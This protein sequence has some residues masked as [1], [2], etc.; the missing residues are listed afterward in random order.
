MKGD[1]IGNGYHG[2]DL[3]FLPWLYVRGVCNAD[4]CQQSAADQ[5]RQ[6]GKVIYDIGHS[7]GL[8][9]DAGPV[10]QQELCLFLWMALAFFNH[11]QGCFVGVAKDGKHR[12]SMLV[13]KGIVAPFTGGNARTVG[14]QDG[15]KLGAREIKLLSMFLLAAYPEHVAVLPAFSV[16]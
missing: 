4:I 6:F 14:R 16:G 5:T 10:T 11:K 13:I 15:A 3:H 8:A 7:T 2:Q 9:Q 1:I 12:H